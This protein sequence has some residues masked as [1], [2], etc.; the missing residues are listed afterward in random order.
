MADEK[1]DKLYK[2]VK[3]LS[4]TYKSLGSPEFIRSGSVV[5]DALLGGGI[6]RGVFILWS[7]DSGTGKSTGSLH[8]SWSYCVQGKKVLY[9]DY[10]GGV[11]ESQLSGIGLSEYLYDPETNPNG[12]FFLFKCQ[13]YKDGEKILD[14]IMEE[15]DLVII[16]S[17][18]S[19]LTEKVKGSSSED[20]LPGIN[21]RV[22]S[23]FLQKYKAEAIRLGVTWIM[24]NQIRTKIGMGFGQITQDVAAGGNALRFYPDIRL[25][26]KKAYKG[27]LEREEE[28]AN[29]KQKSRFG[30]ICSI[31]AEKNRY[32]RPDIPLNLAIIFGLGI[33]NSYAYY[34]RLEY[35]GA[36]KK[37]GAWFE[38]KFGNFNEKIN[39]MAKVIEFIENHRK[40][41]KEYINSIGGYKLLL[42]DDKKIN[43]DADEYSDGDVVNEFDSLVESYPNSR[44]SEE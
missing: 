40:E 32:A 15:V 25:R 44:G 33:N 9:L 13:T 37:S 28:T 19:I 20:V 42:N 12:T 31:W 23:T 14:E 8:V 17:M 39:G 2:S 36:I 10:E 24:I 41:V 11:N 18:T 7:A 43:I 35:D 27:D 21:A 22:S 6:P 29:G 1:L 34:D 26:M 4:K 3:E 5:L 38:V 30:A 16:D